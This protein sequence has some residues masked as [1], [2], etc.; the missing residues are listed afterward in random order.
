[1]RLQVHNAT[2]ERNNKGVKI[3]DSQGV[4]IITQ[5]HVHILHSALRTSMWYEDVVVG[6]DCNDYFDYSKLFDFLL[7]H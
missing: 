7:F 1:M 6:P 5:P 2:R 3:W 4:L